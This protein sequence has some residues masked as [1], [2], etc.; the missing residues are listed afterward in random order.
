MGLPIP[1][2]QMNSGEKLY[3]LHVNFEDDTIPFR[4]VK[5]MDH[6]VRSLKSSHILT[7]PTEMQDSLLTAYFHKVELSTITGTIHNH[8]TLL[9]TTFVWSWCSCSA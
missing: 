2:G 1:S 5:Y 8:P 6:A 3:R 9:V 4:T 7:P